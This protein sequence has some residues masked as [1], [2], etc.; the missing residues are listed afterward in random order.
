MTR[1]TRPRRRPRTRRIRVSIGN[2]YAKNR[3]LRAYRRVLALWFA[4]LLVFLSEAQWIGVVPGYTRHAGDG[5]RKGE[6]AVYWRLG[7]G[8]IARAATRRVSKDVTHAAKYGHA[9]YVTTVTGLLRSV[10]VAASAV[11]LNPGRRG[12]PRRQNIGIINRLARETQA[13][14]AAGRV[15]L[16][17]GD[18]NTG[19]NATGPDSPRHLAKKIGPGAQLHMTGIDG[20]IVAAPRGVAVHVDTKAR[21]APGSNHPLLSA[22]VAVTDRGDR[23]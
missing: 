19:E 4:P 7:L 6:T 8:R 9:R 17:G 1:P 10:S 5:R 20:L 12:A 22:T 15:V 21:R 16:I 11:H 23:R 13:H 18:W 3:A 2:V 14:L